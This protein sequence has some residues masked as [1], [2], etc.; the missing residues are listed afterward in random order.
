MP[1]RRSK[2]LRGKVRAHDP[3]ELIRWLALSQP[4]PRKALAELVQNSL[5]ADARTIRVTR[6][7]LKGV[8]SLRIFDDGEGVIPEMDR[9]DALHYLATHIGHSR[10]RS[11]SPEQR[12]RLMTQ[13]Q[14]G[15]GLLGFWSIGGQ[16]EIRTVVPGEPPLRLILYQDRPEFLIE[17]LRGRLPLGERWTE[18][19][20][21]GIHPEALTP[22][23]GRRAADYLASELRGQLLAR[24]VDLI[25]EDKMARGLAQ[26]VITVR[27]PRFLGERLDGLPA[28]IEVPGH[29]AA[30]LEIYSASQ[31][32][33]GEPSPGIGVYCAGTLVAEDFRV[34]SALGLDRAPWTDRRLIGMVDFPGFRVT[35]GSRRSIV[36]DEAAAA[37][38]R[39]LEKVEPQ[40]AEVLQQ[41]QRQRAEEADRNLV[42]DLQRAFRDFYRQR[43]S[44]ALLPVQA[45]SDAGSGGAEND[46]GGAGPGVSVD[47]VEEDKP[48][49]VPQADLLPPGPLDDVRLTPNPL[50]VECRGSRKVR[51]TPV[52]AGGRAISSGVS[53]EWSTVGQVGQL[54]TPARGGHSVV[55]QANAQPTTGAIGVI[56]RQDGRQASG[57]STVEIVEQLDSGRSREGIPTPEFVHEPGAGWRSRM[58]E[59]RWQVNS[60]HR[61][62]R[63]VVDRPTLKLRYL[64]MLFAK[65]IV[66]RSHQ[67]RR[68][69]TPLE[70]LVEV[71]GYADRNLSQKRAPRRR[72]KIPNG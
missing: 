25:V 37:F 19:I 57:R 47:V 28:E 41:L 68:L 27:P 60:G 11:L 14:Y 30:H 7:R 34:L 46:G 64:A 17:P 39:A 3:F 4:D 33:E 16:L 13:G 24:T 69:E 55:L 49:S 40:I 45:Q 56:A 43:P 50:R 36:V 18:V 8:P 42:R 65:E 70:Q 51:A 20:V 59:E 26:K 72:S 23:G 10:K 61:E 5:D 32:D 62:F 63:A 35:P 58:L 22:L 67:D 48:T 44:Y 21:A 71:A 53:Y 1:K 38:A 52:D 31:S 54:E 9:F 6:V 2:T 66:L 12:L 29:V 15:I